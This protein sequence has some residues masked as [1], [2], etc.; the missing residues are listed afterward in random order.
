MKCQLLH[1]AG[2]LAVAP[3]CV[4]NSQFLF[5]AAENTFTHL[6]HGLV[7]ELLLLSLCPASLAPLAL[8][9]RIVGTRTLGVS[10]TKQTSL[11]QIYLPQEPPVFHRPRIHTPVEFMDSRRSRNLLKLSLKYC[12]CVHTCIFLGKVHGF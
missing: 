8:G 5:T 2:R 3:V 6:P 7:L 10:P 11:G 9:Q 12:M 1:W 4:E